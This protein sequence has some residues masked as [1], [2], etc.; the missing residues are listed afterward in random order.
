MERGFIPPEAEVAI[1]FPAA[2]LARRAG[3]TIP[4][5][6][7]RDIL[8]GMDIH[9]P[10]INNYGDI[11]DALRFDMLK[12]TTDQVARFIQEAYRRAGNQ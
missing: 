6:V 4:S 8:A 9:V 7:A 1:G 10:K 11:T 5:S 12:L 2:E 3:A